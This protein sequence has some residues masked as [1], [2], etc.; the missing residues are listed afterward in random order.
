[1]S[2]ERFAQ[3]QA[4][5]LSAGERLIDAVAQPE[6]DFMRDAVIERFEFTFEVIWKVLKL[7]L[8]RQ[9]HECGGLRATLKKAS[10]EKLIPTPE[11]AKRWMQMLEARNLASHAYD[12]ALARQLYA[13]A[14]TIT[15][16]RSGR[17]PRKSKH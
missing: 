2:K 12:E 9:G 13:Q 16:L 17:W 14:F 3:R 7:Y 10:A 1:V 5:A 4:V 15:P 8:E 11:E 6:T